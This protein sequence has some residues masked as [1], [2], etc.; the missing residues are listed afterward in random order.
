MSTPVRRHR[1]VV[2]LQQLQPFFTQRATSF[3]SGAVIRHESIV[4][5]AQNA[6]R[7]LLLLPGAQQIVS[8]ALT[9][10]GKLQNRVRVMHAQRHA[11]SLAEIVIAITIAAMMSSATSIMYPRKLQ[12]MKDSEAQIGIDC[13]KGGLAMFYSRYRRFPVALSELVSSGDLVQLGK[14]PWGRDYIYLP[15]VSWHNVIKMC[16]QQL[17]T[18]QTEADSAAN[19]GTAAMAAATLSNADTHLIAA[20]R[21]LQSTLD[22]SVCVTFD[23]MKLVTAV[24]F[25][26]V[27]YSYGSRAPIISPGVLDVTPE[28]VRLVQRL[29][30]QALDIAVDVP[31]MLELLRPFEQLVGRAESLE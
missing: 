25:N 15:C 11:F 7:F 20:I 3:S 28:Q 27:V 31:A 5:V 23:P 4:R 13:I 21:H 19:T 22:S 9:I 12:D 26:P 30:R 6:I 14:D 18:L 24:H 8:R 17:K 16:E 10:L 1:I 29:I 2:L